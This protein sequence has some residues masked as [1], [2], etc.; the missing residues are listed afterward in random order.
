MNYIVAYRT[1]VCNT[2]RIISDRINNMNKRKICISIVAHV[3]AGKTTLAEGILYNCNKLRKLGRVDHGDAALDYYTIERERG[4]TVFSKQAQAEYKDTVITLLDTPGHVDFSV[5]TER[6][7][8]ILDAAILVISAKDRIQAHTLTLWRLLKEYN[9]PTVIF[10]NKMDQPGNDPR[11]ITDVLKSHLDSS[12]IS[13]PDTNNSYAL[14]VSE[15]EYY[16]ELSMCNEEMMEAYLENGT[17][18][19]KMIMRAVKNRDVFPVYFGSALNNEGIDSLLDGITEYLPNDMPSGRNV[20]CATESTNGAN[21]AFAARVFKIS[22]EKGIR[23][24]HV[25]ITSGSVRVKSNITYISSTGEEITEKIDQIR[26]L[27]CSGY[28]TRDI[29]EVGDVCCLVG[30]SATF[31]GQGLGDED[32]IM[33]TS[34]TPVLTYRVILPEGADALTAYGKL[35][36]LYEEIPE[37]NVEWKEAGRQIHVQVM[38]DVQIEILKR[39]IKDRFDMEVEFANGSIVYKET[40]ATPAEGVGHYEPLKHYAEVHLLLQPA[41]P[42]SGLRFNSLCSVDELDLNWQRLIMTH[43]EEKTHVGVLGGF[44]ITDMKISIIAGRAHVK[45]TEGGDFRQATYRAIRQ[46]LMQ[47][48]CHLLEPYYAYEIEVPSEDIGRVLSDIQKMSGEFEAPE[49]LG[50]MTRI[51]G[52]CPVVTMRDYQRDIN[53]YTHGLGRI[54]LRTCGYR[55]C[56]NEE[57]VLLEL[58]YNPDADLDNPASSIFCSHGAGTLVP[59]YEVKEMAHVETNLDA[60]SIRKM[61]DKGSDTEDDYAE[62]PD[63]IMQARALASSSRMASNMISQEEI[64]KIYASSYGQSKDDLLPYRDT[65]TNG[66]KVVSTGDKKEK[67]YVYKPK[68]KQ[69]EYLLVDGYNIIFADERLRDLS[70]VNIDSARDALIDICCNYQGSRGCTLILVYDAYKVKGNPGNIT[71]YNNIYVVY[72][73]EAETADM[74]IEKTVHKMAKK[75]DVAVATSDGL[76]QMIIFGDGAKRI[77]AKGFM[78]LIKENE[79]MVR[80]TYLS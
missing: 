22:R 71:K 35:K 11:E 16:D 25:K 36:T 39:L 60:D 14:S 28:D 40:I 13:M 66:P 74:Y 47:C 37:M 8:G 24:T 80:D 23:L 7:L 18:D 73:K 44:P 77:S 63:K 55:P 2:N 78:E 46:G 4:I 31:S 42:G 51:V 10:V 64:E 56:H 68:E 49:T 76:E 43:L 5:E 65:S 21:A 53:Q 26:F 67:P 69:E 30:L 19:T 48:E 61:I 29:A 33:Q 27:D 50:D 59:W 70:R 58:N 3:D 9:V 34:L 62:G 6:T 17:I 52:T 38:G 20:A 54:V 1:Y 72:T 79:K 57:E 15:D 41:E 45:H 32:S 75:A 12:I